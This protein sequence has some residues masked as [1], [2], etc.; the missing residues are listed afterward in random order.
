MRVSI[1]L[2]RALLTVVEVE[3]T[4]TVRAL[5]QIIEAQFSYK[6]EDQSLI[7]AKR[8]LDGRRTLAYYNVDAETILVLVVKLRTVSV[9]VLF[10]GAPTLVEVPR[11]CNIGELK[12]AVSTKLAHNRESLRVIFRGATLTDQEKLTDLHLLSPLYLVLSPYS[13]QLAILGLNGLTEKVEVGADSLISDVKNIIVRSTETP[14]EGFCLMCKEKVLMDST[15]VSDCNI[16]PADVVKVVGV[17]IG[18]IRIHSQGVTFEV[19]ARTT[20]TISLIKAKILV[21]CSIPTDSQR[22]VYTNRCLEDHKTLQELKIA[23]GSTL[24]LTIIEGAFPIQ[25]K[26]REG[27]LL[28]LTVCRT[29]SVMNVKVMIKLLTSISLDSQVLRFEGKELQDLARL[30]DSGVTNGSVI[31]VESRSVKL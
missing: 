23:M 22:L 9:S 3:P 28:N 18:K 27:S 25:V 13:R 14:Y 6:V 10:K 16:G 4:C 12:A 5:K 31:Y 17:K 29:D 24:K 15:R 2:Q 26:Q 21:K 20:D 30:K 19:Q 1:H 7:F 11:Q 8:N